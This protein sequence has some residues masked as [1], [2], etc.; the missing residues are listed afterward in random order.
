MEINVGVKSFKCQN[1]QLCQLLK[2]L[3]QF[4]SSFSKQF[5][6]I[7]VVSHFSIHFYMIRSKIIFVYLFCTIKMLCRKSRYNYHIFKTN[8]KTWKYYLWLTK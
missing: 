2:Y 3:I 4:V 6:I 7:F 1:W 8:I 5:Y